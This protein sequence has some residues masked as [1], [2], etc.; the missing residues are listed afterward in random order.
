M[1]LILHRWH[2]HEAGKCTE[3]A[4]LHIPPESQCIAARRATHQLHDVRSFGQS[5]YLGQL[6]QPCAG[7]P[8]WVGDGRKKVE[9]TC[10]VKPAEKNANVALNPA[11]VGNEHLCNK[12]ANLLSMQ[13]PLLK[14][15]SVQNDNVLA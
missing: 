2:G 4:S 13:I 11:F 15:Q 12:E 7:K 14:S 9:R 5:E 8:L 3:Q 10:T 1:Q 6:L